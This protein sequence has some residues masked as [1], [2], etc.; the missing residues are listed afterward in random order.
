ML[1]ALLHVFVQYAMSYGNV[2]YIYGHR[3][4]MYMATYRSYI[5][6]YIFENV[7]MYVYIYIYIAIHA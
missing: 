4:Y 7:A 1:Y 2:Y 5:W 6:P 3:Y